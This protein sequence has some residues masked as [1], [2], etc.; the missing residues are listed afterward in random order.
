MPA[1]TVERIRRV[2]RKPPGYLLER[3]AQEG[4]R[5]A[6]RWLAPRRALAMTEPNL[7]NLLGAPSVD[8][9]WRAMLDRPYPFLQQ[10][11][12]AELEAIAP[13]EVD[14]IR[15]AAEDALAHRVDLL[16]AGPVDLGAKIDWHRDF[17]TGRRWP[18]QYCHA[19]DYANLDQPSDVKSPWELSRL[20]WLIPAAQ[21]YRL[22]GDERY[23]DGVREVLEQWIATNP[24]A[25]SVNWSCTMEAALRLL[26]FG[27]L[28]RAC[29]ESR[30]FADKGFRLALL[31]SLVL[32]A[33]FTDR[34]IER[35]DIN[36]NHYT[37]DAAGLVF[38]GLFLGEGAQAKV[39]L[40]TGW[41]IL[42]EEIERQ[43]FPDG[44][45]FEA[46]T[47]YHRLVFELFL[48]PALYGQA[49]GRT[50][51]DVWRE[52]L[53]AMARFT[54]A[55]SRN[56]GRLPNWGDS[57]DARALP[58]AGRGLFDHRYLIGLARLGLDEASLEP[59]IGGPV[60]ELAWLCGVP[61][62][63]RLAGRTRTARHSEAFPKGGFYVLAGDDDHVFVDC[64]PVGLG[65]RGG[66]GHNDLLS[67]EAALEG[68]R[69]IVDPGA[70]V[71]TASPRER[72]AFRS[73]AYH[74][75]PQA[76]G[77]EIYRF[78]P[79]ELWSL[80]NDADPEVRL[81]RPGD[82]STTLVISHDGFE[83]LSPPIRLVRTIE[84]DHLSHRLTIE[85]AFQGGAGHAL[86]SPLHLA[87]EVT[88]RLG[89]EDGLVILETA[90]GAF[91][92]T[93]RGEG[94]RVSLQDARVSP[95]YGVVHPS[96]KLVFRA[97]DANASLQLS[98]ARVV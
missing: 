94:W 12:R 84:L 78:L 2:L 97:D 32:H 5:A 52:R 43:V 13:G 76:D 49:Q 44:V 30:A 67:F 71:Y 79:H 85:D 55:Y 64:G 91:H 10:V 72:N 16:G 9:A 65:G 8:A 33:D 54:A 96:R 34:Y 36:G 17:K 38:A 25:G 14:R 51:P 42:A 74:N 18:P 19:I 11:T 59:L 23:A 86:T 20:Q 53:V 81:W 92:L 83:R 46:S 62:A 27:W 69:L 82:A 21:A 6:D 87:P 56:D 45:D 50:L 39:W 41:T 60:A 57:D 93:W 37:A 7:L 1:L 77:E 63:E 58:M 61:A 26:T 70:F 95:S 3:V 98:V 31:R 4:R 47:A 89:P 40:E 90:R 35:S 88:P 29:G 24:Y 80:S 73:T 48:L 66:H 68:E 28:I 22:F 15:S 75:T